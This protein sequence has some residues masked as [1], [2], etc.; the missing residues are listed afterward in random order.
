MK[1]FDWKYQRINWT[2]GDESSVP[3]IL[4]I[5][6][7]F[8]ITARLGSAFI[9]RTETAEVTRIPFSWYICRN[10]WEKLF[11]ITGI[12]ACVQNSGI[13]LWNDRGKKNNHYILFPGSP[14]R[15]ENLETLF[16][17]LA[18][19]V[20]FND[21]NRRK[22]VAGSLSLIKAAVSDIPARWIWAIQYSISLSVNAGQS[23]LAW[24]NIS[25]EVE[26]DIRTHMGRH[27]TLTKKK[28]D[29]VTLSLEAELLT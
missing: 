17:T 21:E 9:V 14:P 23:Y 28:A 20:L 2:S 19:S 8:V 15:N 7:F 18:I 11:S 27:H 3:D 26:F 1:D 25:G 5:A 12:R 22:T 10:S 4:R 29:R 16:A 24:C 6:N 13:F